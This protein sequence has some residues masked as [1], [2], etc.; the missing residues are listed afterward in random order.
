MDVCPVVVTVLMSVT[1]SPNAPKPTSPMPH[2]VIIVDAYLVFAL[3]N[4]GLY[5]NQRERERVREREL[6]RERGRKRERE[7]DNERHTDGERRGE[8]GRDGER[9]R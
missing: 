8:T 6:E 1:L 3:P 5:H 2:N 7:A 4:S 9:Q